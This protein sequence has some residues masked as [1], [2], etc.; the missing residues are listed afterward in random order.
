MGTNG[1]SNPDRSKESDS[2][3]VWKQY[4]ENPSQEL[5]NK[6]ILMHYGV[7]L[8]HA[9]RQ[10]IRLRKI[11]SV[12]ELA[13]YGLDGLIDAINAFDPERGIRFETFCSPRIWGSMI[14]GIREMDWI[15][16]LV[17]SRTRKIESARDRLKLSLGRDP[18]PEEI[19]EELKLSP[20]QYE[21][22]SGDSQPKHTNSLSREVYG[23]Q[24]GGREVSQI[25]FIEDDGCEKPGDEADRQ[26]LRRFM[27]RGL[28]QKSRLIIILHHFEGFSMKEV[29]E[30][31][32]MSES[33]ISQMHT[34]AID[35]IRSNLALKE[36][37]DKR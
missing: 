12:E 34:A 30:I 19:R 22:E 17:R 36:L 18:T 9:K 13:S 28:D 20:E 27:T 35:V 23:N 24:Q 26:D 29:G 16:R 25:D 37:L 4:K 7:L 15:P 11:L 8:G 6:L 31:L 3:D 2:V 33:R 32:F 1:K 21:K 14:D 5:R 10:H